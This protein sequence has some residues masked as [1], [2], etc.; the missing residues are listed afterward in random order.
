MVRE[1]VV[2]FG[3][4]EQRTK[5]V[6]FE[7]LVLLWGWQEVLAKYLLIFTLYT[8]PQDPPEHRFHNSLSCSYS[9]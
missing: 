1:Q 6:I 7:I 5:R 4:L 8:L 2:L 3:L 9:R